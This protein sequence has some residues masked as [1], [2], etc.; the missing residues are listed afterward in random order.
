MSDITRNRWD[1]LRQYTPARIATGRVGHAQPTRAQLQF[2]LD[3]AR[4]RDAV[5]HPLDSA[6]LAERLLKLGP[7][8]LRVNSE[9]SDRAQYLQRPDLGRRLARAD[10]SRLESAVGA[11]GAAD[12]AIAVVDGLS[13]IA[14]ET[15]AAPLL[16][17]LLPALRDNGLKL[18]P[19][20]I[21]AQG[22]VAIGDEIGE[23]LGARLSLVLIGERP[24]LSS[25]DSLG[26][27]LTFGPRRGRVDAERN[28][29]S[30]IRPPHGLDYERAVETCL[31]LCRNALQRRLSGVQ[32]K[33]DSVV[34][35]SPRT[36]RV[37]FFRDT[38]GRG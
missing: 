15:H 5:W 36:Q 6:Q 35:D 38:R 17:R 8:V 4:A 3:H 28:C 20:S 12:V 27:Y 26:L 37:P 18:A 14:V 9:V 16:E 34:V 19:L 31:Y 33:D 10:R 11:A 30:N 23:A 24:G 22:R 2:Q 7:P 21:V 25:P 1:S 29:V 13:S 32:L